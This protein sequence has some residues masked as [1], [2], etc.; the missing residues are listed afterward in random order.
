[1][2]NIA[3]LTLFLLST[4]QAT[5]LSEYINKDNC[6]Q[7]IDKQVFTI[8]YDYKMKGA[9]YVAYTLD[10][11]KV[12]SV[13]IKKRQKFY[14][15]KNLPTKY[16]STSKDY[17]HSNYDRGH[18][19]SDA[20]FDYDEK[21]LSKTYTMANIIPQAPNVNQKT[22]VK[23][24]KLE[25]FIASKLGSVNVIN[26]VVYNSNPKRIGKNRIAVPIAYWKMIYNDKEKYKKCFYYENSNDIDIKDRLKSH[27]VDCNLLQ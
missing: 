19:A 22:W 7:I 3:L 14:T 1:M 24:E 25:R 10:G 15:E 20:S 6:S 12:N 21:S 5:D 2:K 17:A 26:G 23:A 27:L 13:N 16:R 18:I 11:N 8:C 4:L 9:K